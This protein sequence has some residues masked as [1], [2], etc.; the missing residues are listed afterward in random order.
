MFLYGDD[1]AEGRSA[2]I[3]ETSQMGG[4]ICQVCDTIFYGHV[5]AEGRSLR[6]FKTSVGG[7]LLRLFL[8]FLWTQLCRGAVGSD[9]QNKRG[10][11]NL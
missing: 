11:C 5:C 8:P 3:L 2:R 9:L 4:I 10:V 6:I 7:N 1:C